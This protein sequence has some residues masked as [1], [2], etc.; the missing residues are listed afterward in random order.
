MKLSIEKS[1][2]IRSVDLQIRFFEPS[3]DTS[4]LARAIEL[5][6]ERIEFCFSRIRLRGYSYDRGACFDHLHGDQS[7]TFFYFASN[8]AWSEFGDERL[9]KALFLLN[10]MRNGIVIM[11]DTELPSIFLL[12]H[13]VGTVLGKAR[14]S[15]YFVAYQNVTVG[16]DRG[17]KPQ[18]DERVVMYSGSSVLGDCRIGHGVTFAAQSLL[19]RRNVSAD[20]IV[21]G[22]HP[23]TILTP[24]IKDIASKYFF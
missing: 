16:T 9:A 21:S 23:E 18:L 6:L 22:R 14:Y 24:A 5:A 7:A 11:Y 13:S 3:I 12:N 1:D 15:D 8:S 20:T 10:K 17:S 4:N 19:L 2:L